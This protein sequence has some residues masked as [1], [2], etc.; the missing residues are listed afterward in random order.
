LN[1]A[2]KREVTPGKGKIGVPL[3]GLGIEE[4]WPV[5]PCE[6]LRLY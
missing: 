4:E 3:F 6:K 1:A 5:T 2:F